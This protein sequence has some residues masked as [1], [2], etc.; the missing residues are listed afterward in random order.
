MIKE[1]RWV[2][3]STLPTMKRASRAEISR[4]KLLPWMLIQCTM[5]MMM[6]MMIQ[7]L[8]IHNKKGTEI[9]VRKD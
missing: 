1:L 2:C 8:M 6:M 4:T 7:I 9:A 5:M 3:E